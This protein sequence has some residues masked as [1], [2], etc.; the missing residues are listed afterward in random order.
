M[1]PDWRKVERDN[2]GLSVRS[3]RFI[4]QGW[5][6]C[7]YVVNNEFV[8]R[9]PKHAGHW[10]EMEREIAFL[11][12]AA[13]KLPVPVPR[14]LRAAPHSSAAPHG[15]AIYKYLAGRAMDASGLTRERRDAAAAVL[16]SFLKTLHALQPSPHIAGV[17]PRDDE[18]LAARDYFVR[19]ERA[20]IPRLPRRLGRTL[21]EV[22]EMHLGGPQNFVAPAVLHADFGADHILVENSAVTGVIDFGDVNWGDPDYDFMYL[23]VDFGMPFFEDVARRYGHTDLSR[24]RNKVR[25]FGIVDQIDTILEDEGRALDGQKEKAWIRLEQLLQNG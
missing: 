5:N 4:G 6:A 15:Y 16:A 1:Q 13:D 18:R 12:F 22:F 8:F 24:L 7:A 17:L 14:Y 2:P 21:R 9:F 10:V 23:F 25:Y 20:V 19:A 3:A 11:A